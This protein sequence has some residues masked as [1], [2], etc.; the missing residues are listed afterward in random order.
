MST[1]RQ[2]CWGTLTLAVALALLAGCLQIETHVRLHEDGSATITERI[3]LSQRLLEA[4]TRSGGG[5]DILQSIGKEAALERMKAMGKGMELESHEVRQAE[6]GAKEAIAVYRIGDISNF[7]YVSP[8]LAALDYPK[9]SVLQ[10]TLFP[11]YESTWYGRRA[12]QM[13]VIFKPASEQRGNPPEPGKSPTPLDQQVLRDLR[14]VFADMLKDFHVRFTFESYA[15]LRF[16]QYYRYR[17]QGA[18]TKTYD[19]ID[20][21]D[22]D[23]DKYGYDFLRNEEIMLELLGLRADGPNTVGHVAEHGSNSTV[24]V[25][26]PRGTPEI[27]FNPSR[28]LFDRLFQGKTL[29]FEERDGGARP[30]DFNE[31]GYKEA[32]RQTNAVPAT[33]AA[34]PAAY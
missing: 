33:D 14:P 24:P 12:G 4:N 19:L 31:I 8:Y 21:S 10:C 17:G 28:A 23:L 16:R 13:A 18:G 15:P 11:V 6:G 9:H 29:K 20:F 5:P 25:Y 27:Y 2:S 32:P 1:G 26:H 22:R 30:A 3:R 34:G 7:R